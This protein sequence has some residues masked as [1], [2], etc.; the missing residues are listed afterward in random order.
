MASLRPQVGVLNSFDCPLS[1]K[2]RG[3]HTKRLGDDHHKR[4]YALSIR[5]HA[6]SGVHLINLEEI[7]SVATLVKGMAL[8]PDVEI[9]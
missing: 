6:W 5:V 3:A 1:A 2:L 8:E 9:Q 4:I 7:I